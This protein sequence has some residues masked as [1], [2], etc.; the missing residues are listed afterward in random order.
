MPRKAG[1]KTNNQQNKGEKGEETMGKPKKEYPQRCYILKAIQDINEVLGNEFTTEDVFEEV[2]TILPD[3]TLHGVQVTIN[4]SLAHSK[5][6]RTKRTAKG[7]AGRVKVR[8][9]TELGA[10]QDW[11]TT[12]VGYRTPKGE[13]VEKPKRK[14]TKKTVDPPSLDDQLKSKTADP[15]TIEQQ[16]NWAEAL[17]N[18]VNHLNK[19]IELWQYKY[20]DLVRSRNKDVSEWRDVVKGRDRTIAT[21]NERITAMSA[22]LKRQNDG[23]NLLKD[24]ATFK[25]SQAL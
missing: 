16:I 10:Q 20:N 22:R 7:K 24:V 18:Y 2:K 21:L 11:R 9:L 1:Y 25:D 17:S 5:L 6:I 13:K 14:Y 4:K 3:V 15:M 23:R 12:P 8:E 19:Q